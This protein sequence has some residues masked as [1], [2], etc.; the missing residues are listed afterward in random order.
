MMQTFSV[1]LPSSTIYVS[2]TVNGVSVVWTNTHDNTW[3]AVSE[4]SSDNKY[5]VELQIIDSTGKVSAK[6]ITIYYGLNLITDRVASDVGN[7]YKGKYDWEDL[8]RV[9]SAVV[10]LIDRLQSLPILLKDFAS[11]NEVAWDDFF[12][13]PYNPDD[14]NLITKTV[15]QRE[16]I[17]VIEELQRYLNNVK[18]LRAA[19]EYETENLPDNMLFLTWDGANA[20][21]KALE[22]L[23]SE[24]SN[25]TD[26][27]K[28]S[29][30]NTANAFFYSNEIYGGE[31]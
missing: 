9:E 31:V 8:N 17:P 23:D 16:E 26:K 25:L 3:E 13:V 21:E 27:I 7:N 15:W 10:Y 29:I 6:S 12:D 22:L 14:Y 30:K 4:K 2:G 24:I 28:N 20:I 11:E 1:N 19:L 5:A 18:K